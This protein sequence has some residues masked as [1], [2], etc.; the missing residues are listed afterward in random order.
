MSIEDDIAQ[1]MKGKPADADHAI[2]ALYALIAKDT[3][4]RETVTFI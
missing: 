1:I 2:D 3:S 4:Q